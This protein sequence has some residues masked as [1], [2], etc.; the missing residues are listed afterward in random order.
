MS[1]QTTP[2]FGEEA[3]LPELTKVLPAADRVRF[4]A[5]GAL[6]AFTTARQK[7]LLRQEKMLVARHG[8]DSEKAQRVRRR[9]EKEKRFAVATE[10]QAQR[11]QAE[12][13][14]R[15]P[16]ALT[17]HGRV[18]N[19][20][21]LAVR[22]LTAS[23]VDEQGKPVV[24]AATNANGYFMLS[25][26]ASD[27]TTEESVTLLVSDANKAVLY[28]GRE[29]FARQPRKVF[30]RELGI[31]TADPETQPAPPPEIDPR[32]VTVPDVRGLEEMTARAQVRAVGLQ[33][34]STTQAGRN[35]DV[36]RVMEQDPAAGTRVAP[37]SVVK[38]VVGAASR[39][40]VPDLLGKTLREAHAALKQAQLTV[41]RVE[42]SEAS[43]VSR[44]VQQSPAAGAQVPAESTVD[45]V[46]REPAPQVMVPNVVRLRLRDARETLAAAML[47]MGTVQ[48][49]GVSEEGLVVEQSPSARSKADEGAAVNL[50]VRERV[51]R[52]A[53]PN[54]VRRTLAEAK[55]QLIEA[56]LTLGKVEPEGAPD[57]GVVARQNPGA[58]VE[59]DQGTAV[60]LVI[61]IPSGDQPQPGPRKRQKKS[62]G[63]GSGGKGA[64][65]ASS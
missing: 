12:V 1:K 2:R 47:R 43:L 8:A 19:P 57:R 39:V 55:A 26:P 14:A 38:L 17:L 63:K 11:T 44:V 50:T 5:L 53:V 58:G 34:E 36:G 48:P 46:T 16:D 64:S 62:K 41:G 10:A 23:A 4:V 29:C 20:Q 49:E 42:P 65:A 21:R 24:F 22:G 61:E 18:V 52:Q 59:V 6:S 15:N 33:V 40:Q 37:C 7:A 27:D 28:Q 9:L 31:G 3:A 60:N 25:V 45:L 51:L 13:L 32:A 30:Y 56:K 54:L 35:E